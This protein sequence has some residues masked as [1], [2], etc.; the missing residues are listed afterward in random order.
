MAEMKYSHSRRGQR[1]TQLL[2]MHGL[3]AIGRIWVL[4]VK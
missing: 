4:S 1:G 2:I 3:Y